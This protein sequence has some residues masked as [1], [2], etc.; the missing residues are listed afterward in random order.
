MVLGVLA[1]RTAAETAVARGSVGG[2]V[3]NARAQPVQV[4]FDAADA[5]TYSAGG[6]TRSRSNGMARSHV[7]ASC[8]QRLRCRARASMLDSISTPVGWRMMEDG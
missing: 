4:R 8:P 7:V 3:V 2:D 5:H 1:A 6:T